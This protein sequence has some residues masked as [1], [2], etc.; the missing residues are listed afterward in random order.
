MCPR[1]PRVGRGQWM[2]CGLLLRRLG[3][4]VPSTGFVAGPTAFPQPSRCGWITDPFGLTWQIV[5]KRLME[6]VAAD[7]PNK[8]KAVIEAMWQ[9]VKL[10]VAALERTY[11]EG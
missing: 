8:V 10:D 1:L 4:T 3:S 9:M 6:L 5:P 11:A 2:S 7:D